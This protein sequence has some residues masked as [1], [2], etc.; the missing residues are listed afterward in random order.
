MI[1]DRIAPPLPNEPSGYT[2]RLASLLELWW[3]QAH[4]NQVLPLDDRFGVLRLMTGHREDV[5]AVVDGMLNLV[6]LD[7]GLGPGVILRR[8]RTTAQRQAQHEYAH[9]PHFSTIP[10]DDLRLLWRQEPASPRAPALILLER[11]LSD[12]YS[13]LHPGDRDEVVF[14]V[15]RRIENRISLGR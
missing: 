12:S 1:G 8:T 14:L 10:S 3:E 15:Q 6:G 13:E 5:A 2:E 11:A 9:R 7:N 4:A